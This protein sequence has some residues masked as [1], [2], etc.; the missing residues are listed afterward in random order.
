MDCDELIKA[1]LARNVLELGNECRTL[2]EE[3]K[4]LKYEAVHDAGQLGEQSAEIASLKIEI[5]RLERLVNY[6]KIEAQV[7]HER[8]TRTLEHLEHIRSLK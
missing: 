7:D 3:N 2:A 1:N 8:W 4:R 5:E 6:W